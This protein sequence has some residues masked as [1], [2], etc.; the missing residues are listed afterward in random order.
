MWY[1]WMVGGWGGRNGKDGSNAT[2]PVFG[3]GLA[4][5]PLE[6]QERLSPVL[7]TGHS[8]RADSGGP[9]KY[10]GGC[11][12]EKGGVLTDAEAT[13]MSYMCDRALEREP[14]AVLE[15]VVEGYVTVG[16]A[17]RDYGV[18]VR[19]L[20]PDL[21]RYELDLEQTG[22]ERERI[23]RERPGWLAEDP[24]R[25]A[26]CYRAGELDVYDL[27]RQYGVIL[28]WGTGELLPNTTRVFREMLQR[29]AL[30]HWEHSNEPA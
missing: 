4:V 17:L 14:E 30:A 20:D 15:D 27:V 9:G 7:T 23:R 26:A 8:I 6:G 18:A 22:R 13:V 5:Q 11:G 19:E 25:T 10:R 29:R 21:A 12:V 3:V 24:E 16:R 28:D 2:A 1:D